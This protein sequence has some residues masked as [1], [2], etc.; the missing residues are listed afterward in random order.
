MIYKVSIQTRIIFSKYIIQ[1]I[2]FHNRHKDWE[3]LHFNLYRLKKFI[4]N[5]IVLQN[6]NLIKIKKTNKK[7]FIFYKLIGLPTNVKRYD[8]YYF[9][10]YDR[11]HRKSCKNCFFYKSEKKYCVFRNLKIKKINDICIDFIHNYS[12]KNQ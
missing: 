5:T 1:T 3:N 12:F 6:Y 10:R 7:E 9:V 8:G 11:P 4:F 2:T